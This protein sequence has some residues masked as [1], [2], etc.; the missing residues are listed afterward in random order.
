MDKSLSNCSLKDVLSSENKYF[1]LLLL[2][3]LESKQLFI[4]L[5]KTSTFTLL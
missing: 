2:L 1:I 4:S 3:G 5:G